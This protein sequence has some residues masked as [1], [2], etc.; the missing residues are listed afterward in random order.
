MKTVSICLKI[1]AWLYILVGGVLA[2]AGMPALIVLCLG[3]AIGVL[4]VAEYIN[5]GSSKAA[6]IGAG[7]MVLYTFSAFFFLGIPGLIG[8]Y[9]DRSNWMSWGEQ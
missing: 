2:L 8:A 9:R 4:I 7:L 3:I 5:R 6:W 1:S